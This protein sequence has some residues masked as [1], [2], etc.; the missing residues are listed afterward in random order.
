MFTQTENGLEIRFTTTSFEVQKPYVWCTRCKLSDSIFID[1]RNMKWINASHNS[2]KEKYSEF[3]RSKHY[4]TVDVVLNASYLLRVES[5]HAMPRF[6]NVVV[7]IRR[8]T[9]VKMISYL[10]PGS[11]SQPGA[12][13]KTPTLVQVYF[14]KIN[15]PHFYS[16]S[17]V[18]WKV[19]GTH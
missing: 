9:L 2:G 12:D 15:S 13:A 5:L 6:P 14:I 1:L 17:M 7:A 11:H 3:V 4:Y 10:Q 8:I 19:E 18:S 16:S